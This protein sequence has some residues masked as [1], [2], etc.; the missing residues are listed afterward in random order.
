MR[1]QKSEGC[2]AAQNQQNHQSE[3]TG[4]A[5]EKNAAVMPRLL[6]PPGEFTVG[7]P[8]RPRGFGF[9]VRPGMFVFHGHNLSVN[10]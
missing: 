1:Q 10:L 9:L 7:M 6:S 5:E 3:N 8:S 4:E 2:H